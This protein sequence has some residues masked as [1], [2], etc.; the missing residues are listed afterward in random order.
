MGSDMW[1]S[2]AMYYD[3]DLEHLRLLS[4]F[5]YV[6]AGAVGLFA[7]LPLIHVAIGTVLVFA[8]PHIGPNGPPALIG[9]LFVFMGGPSC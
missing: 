7:C 1:D 5:H 4:I 9:L 3:K 2:Q 8:A 6:A